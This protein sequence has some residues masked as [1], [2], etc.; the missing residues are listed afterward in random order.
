[1]S[2]TQNEQETTS[3]ERRK[4]RQNKPLPTEID[5][6]Q[7]TNDTDKMDMEIQN[8][9]HKLKKAPSD[10]KYTE[11]DHSIQHTSDPGVGYI[12]SDASFATRDTQSVETLTIVEEELS[13]TDHNFNNTID[14][15]DYTTNTDLITTTTSKDGFTDV[16]NGSPNQNTIRQ[17]RNARFTPNPYSALESPTNEVPNTNKEINNNDTSAKTSMN[18]NNE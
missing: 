10:N 12:G 6:E 15:M 3:P 8:H 14:K 13:I 16:Q 7:Y 4:Q 9:F 18:T 17:C 11:M 1:M 5:F 2:N